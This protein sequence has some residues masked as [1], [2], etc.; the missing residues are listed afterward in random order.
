VAK[1]QSAD[2]SFASVS[3]GDYWA[4]RGEA[5]RWVRFHTHPR[6][7]AFLPWKV[8][9]GPVRKTRLTPGRSTRG[10]NSQ[11]QQFR[12]DDSWE[13]P[14]QSM[15]PTTPWTGR[16]IFLVDKTHADCWGTDQRRQRVEAANF[17]DAQSENGLSRRNLFDEEAHS[18]KP[19]WLKLSE[20]K[21][22][23]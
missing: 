3:G 4:E 5:G 17:Q 14:I 12:V 8:P 19:R 18:T 21:T 7:S 2:E 16:T 1:L 13:R 11:G 22:P 6:V 10:V 20:T 9:G 23:D 15:I